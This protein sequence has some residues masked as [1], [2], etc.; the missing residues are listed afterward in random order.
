MR[1][2][3]LVN[4]QG[5]AALEFVMCLPILL[6]LFVTFLWLGISL[7][8]QSDVTIE[9]RHEAWRERHIGSSGDAFKLK[10][11]VGAVEK[12]VD[13]DVSFSPL[14]DGFADPQAAH[15]VLG[16]PWDHH[17]VLPNDGINKQPNWELTKRI[18]IVSARYKGQAF[19]SGILDGARRQLQGFDPIQLAGTMGFDGLLGNLSGWGQ[20]LEGASQQQGAAYELAKQREK[21]KMQDKIR[22]RE[23]RI[24]QLSS[25]LS[26][27]QKSLAAVKLRQWVLT[28]GGVSPA[29]LKEFQ[30]LEN[31]KNILEGKLKSSERRKA[32]SLFEERR[33]LETDRRAL[34][35]FDRL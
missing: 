6:V 32:N 25:Q 3:L 35:A 1:Q 2:T 11:M 34:R 22:E 4:R 24:Q 20:T 13:R 17:Q 10:K 28:R 8:S 23:A 15:L 12:S 9:A 27:D 26:D 31:R 5:T 21:Q 16:G 19:D 29:E 33:E 30:N 7:S 18:T 14:F